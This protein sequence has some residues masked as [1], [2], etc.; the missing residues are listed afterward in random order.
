MLLTPWLKL[1]S[2]YINLLSLVLDCCH[3]RHVPQK[4]RNFTY[5]HNSSF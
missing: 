5:L 1:Q 2:L 4:R 3:P